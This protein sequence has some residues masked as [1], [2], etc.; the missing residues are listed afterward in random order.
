MFN[1]GRILHGYIA[2]NEDVECALN[3]FIAYRASEK[4]KQLYGFLKYLNELAT[5]LCDPYK[6]NC[7]S[8]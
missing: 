1:Y 7:C 2:K 8:K 5:E 3:I 6:K 4:G